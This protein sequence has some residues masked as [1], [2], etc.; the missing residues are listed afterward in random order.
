[1]KIAIITDTHF[2]VRSDASAM[3]LSMRKFFERVFFPTLD[4]LGITRVLHGGDYG[5]RRKFINFGTS[6]FIEDVYRQPMRTRNIQEDVI[7]GNHDCFYRDSTDINTIT[8]LLRHDTRIRVHAQPTELDVDGCGVLLLPWICGNNRENTERLIATSSCSTVLGHL[9][10]SG[11]QMYRGMPSHD[12]MDP[13][14][15]DRFGLVMSGHYH[16]QSSRNTI[17]YLGAPYP[18]VWSDYQ[19]I[20]G[21]HIFDTTTRALAFVENPYTAFA[22]LVYDDKDA[23]STYVEQLIQSILEPTSPYHDAYIKVVVKSRTQPYWFELMLDALNKVNPQDVMVVDDI[24]SD[25]DV[26]AETVSADIDTATIIHE[27]INAATT[28]CD[29]ADLQM[30]VQHLYREAIATT[31]SSRLS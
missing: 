9:E 20:R 5:D 11:F 10:L 18:M 24:V 16:H 1:M 17:H 13:S 4:A 6:R 27:Y 12:G 7:V 26:S 28:S 23:P 29:K 21:F 8:E 2:G 25:V 30:Y 19:D 31:Q 14:V 22:R 15:F 3:Y